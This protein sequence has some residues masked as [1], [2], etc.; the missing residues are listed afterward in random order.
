MDFILSKIMQR[1]KSVVL[2]PPDIN[3][4]LEEV[5]EVIVISFLTKMCSC[6]VFGQDDNFSILSAYL[7]KVSRSRM[8]ISICFG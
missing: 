4:N 3:M 2:I 5:N 1:P 7:I 8:K 6:W